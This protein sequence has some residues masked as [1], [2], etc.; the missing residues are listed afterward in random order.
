MELLTKAEYA[1]RRLHDDILSGKLPGGSRLVVKD[2]VEEYEVSSLPIRNAIARLEELGLVHTSAHQGAWVSEMNLES[3]FTFMLLRTDAEA[4]AAKL[5][6]TKR[7]DS[8]IQ[9][10]E[11][12]QRQMEAACDAG[13]Y[14]RYGRMNRKIHTLVCA[15]SGNQTLVEQINILMNRTSLAVSMFHII[16]CEASC[17]EHRDW[18]NALRD[19]DA[20]RSA[21]IIRYQRCR[22]NLDLIYALQS[23]SLDLEE[24]QLLKQAV[25]AEGGKECLE[26]FTAIFQEI[27]ANNNY[28]EF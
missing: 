4:L 26:Q 21:A 10:L 18:L 27:E 1:Y 11:Q 13:D 3:Y 5:A 19:K 6:A 12:I 7:E 22:A 15:A 24:N 9:E 20:L 8:L 14:E 16:S 25:A 28:R 17:R 2:L 23:G